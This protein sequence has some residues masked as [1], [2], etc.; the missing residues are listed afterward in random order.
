M[1]IGLR[2][3]YPLFSSSFNETWIFLT[4]FRKILK[5]SNFMKLHPVGGKLFHADR[6]TWQS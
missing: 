4:V 6:Q 3:K 1:Y 2:E 5:I